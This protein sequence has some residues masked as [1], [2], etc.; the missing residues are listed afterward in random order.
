[1][2]QLAEVQLFS[3]DGSP[4]SITAV[5]AEGHG[6]SPYLQQAAAS[7]IDNRTETK[8]VDVAFGTD[9]RVSL[10]MHLPGASSGEKNRALR[11]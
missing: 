1:M 6:P 5:F 11:M 7:A 4:L 8:W 9:R 3:A 10:V 2:L